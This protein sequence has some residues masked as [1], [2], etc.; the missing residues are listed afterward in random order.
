MANNGRQ[1]GGV[2]FFYRK[3]T[4][5]F[6]N[7]PIVIPEGYEVLVAVGRVRGVKDTMRG[8]LPSTG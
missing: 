4:S 3:L 2:A 6:D 7:F 5:T 8:A 1:Y